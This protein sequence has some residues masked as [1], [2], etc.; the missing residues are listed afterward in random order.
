MTVFLEIKAQHALADAAF[1]AAEQKAFDDNNDLEFDSAIRARQRN[2]QAYFLFLFTRLEH[3]V[4]AAVETLLAARLFATPA[5]S[6]RRI[7]QAWA[8]GPVRDVWLLSK[9]EVLTDKSHPDYAQIKEYYDGRNKIA[10]GGIW[11]AQFF[12]ASIAQT[13]HDIVQRFVVA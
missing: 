10:H 11:E 4:N 7:W 13:M 3:A 9:V 2:D 12:I 1:A 5:W 8:R 6:E